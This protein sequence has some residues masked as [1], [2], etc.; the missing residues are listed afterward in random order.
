MTT[1]KNIPFKLGDR[2]IVA[3]NY[4]VAHIGMKGRTI[5]VG[6]FNAGVE[7]DEYI[8]GHSCDDK[9]KNGF[10]YYITFPCLK[11]LNTNAW[12]GQKR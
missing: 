11:K 1:E 10:C 7:F 5:Y 4:G 3:E 9:G 6:N 2:V 8:S 12:T